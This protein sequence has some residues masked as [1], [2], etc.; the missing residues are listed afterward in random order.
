LLGKLSFKKKKGLL[1]FYLASNM[2]ADQQFYIIE[3]NIK[4]VGAQ[5]FKDCKIRKLVKTGVFLSDNILFNGKNKIKYFLR[6]LTF[7]NFNS[8]N[9]YFLITI[10]QGNSLPSLVKINFLFFKILTSFLVYLIN[11]KNIYLNF[12]GRM[13]SS[14]LQ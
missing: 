8:L 11:F 7:S 3:N 12:S 14:A 5:R 9:R 1:E 6:L 2:L 10:K 13:K 4:P